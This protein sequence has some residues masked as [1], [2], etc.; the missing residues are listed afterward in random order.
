MPFKF[1]GKTRDAEKTLDDL[2]AA[3]ATVLVFGN[4]KYAREAARGSS[5]AA[6]FSNLASDMGLCLA[7]LAPALANAA[8]PSSIGSISS[9]I[10]RAARRMEKVEETG[11]LPGA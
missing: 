11:T 9:N 4:D 2:L 6:S 3:S 5:L 1:E 7:T 10:S 8:P